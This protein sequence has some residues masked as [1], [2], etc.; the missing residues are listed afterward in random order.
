MKL[1]TVI[2]IFL[3]LILN[4]AVFADPNMTYGVYGKAKG[5]T[6][7]AGCDKAEIKARRKLDEKITKKGQLLNGPPLVHRC[8][9]DEV[10]DYRKQ[11][12]RILHQ[13]TSILAYRILPQVHPEHPHHGYVPGKELD[14]VL[15]EAIMKY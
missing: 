13:C 8:D 3:A 10:N 15:T 7:A 5:Q 14:E 12:Q 1:T 6:Y 4:N 9:C 11:K 2:A